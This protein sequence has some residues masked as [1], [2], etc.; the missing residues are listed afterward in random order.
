MGPSGRS[1]VSGAGAYAA[2][3]R[4]GL[5]EYRAREEDRDPL[6]DMLVARTTGL[7]GDNSLDGCADG[8]MVVRS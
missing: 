5:L 4:E 7:F 3:A 1:N 6:R 8:D 2:E